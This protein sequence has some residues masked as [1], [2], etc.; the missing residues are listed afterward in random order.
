MSTYLRQDLTQIDNFSDIKIKKL[1]QEYLTQK[2]KEPI[3]SVLL[4]SNLDETT[5]QAIISREHEELFF[6]SNNLYVN[7]VKVQNSDTLATELATFLKMD[8]ETLK[9]K[10]KIR[11]KQHLEI[12]RK[13]SI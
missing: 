13:M 1:I 6:I 9:S 12:I 10:F 4:A 5:I 2:I 8:I 11:P 7:P 3:T